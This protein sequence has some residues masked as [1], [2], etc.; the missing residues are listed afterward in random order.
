M[1]R[2]TLII[3]LLILSSASFAQKTISIKGIVKNIDGEVLPKATVIVFYEG[4]KD[5]IKTTASDKGIF[6][7]DNLKPA[8]TG[9]AVSYS[10]YNAFAQFYNYANAEGQQLIADIALTPGAKTL[11]TVVVQAA[12]IQIKEDTVSYKIDSTMYRKNDNV[13]EVLKKL[14]GVEVDKEGKVTAQGEAITKVRVNGKDFFGGDVTSATRNL[15]ADMVDRLDIIDDYGDQA[16]FTGVKDGASTKTLNIQL[17]KDKNKG[18]FGNA[19]LG[20]GT[21]GRYTNSLTLNRFD[22]ER[23]ISLVGSLNNTNESSF[24]FGAGAMGNTMRN[25]MGSSGGGNGVATTKSLGL[26]YRDSWGKK[27]SVNGSYSYTD[28]ATTLLQDINRQNIFDDGVQ[29][30]KQQNNNN[31]GA[32]IHRVN[33]NL[34]YKIDKFNYLKFTPNVTFNTSENDYTSAFLFTDKNNA[35]INEGV[36]TDFTN[37]KAPNFGGNLLFNHRF[38]AK[39]RILSVNL[40]ANASENTGDD[41]YKNLTTYYNILGGGGGAYDSVF[42]QLIDQNNANSS[43]GGD[44]SYIEPLSKK[45]H[46]DFNY[47]YNYQYVD[48]NRQNFVYD[49]VTN[50][51]NLVDSLSNIYNNEYITNRFGVNFITNEKKYKYTIGMAV[52]PATIQSNSK[53]TNIS[54][55]QNLVNFYP[56]VRFT[57]NFSRSRSFS[58]NYQGSTNQPSY[59]QLQPVYDYSNPQYITVGNPDLKPEFT[60][61]ISMRYNNFDL[62]TGN[63]FFGSINFSLVNDK[64]VNNVFNK[65]GG[66]QETR[67]INENGYYTSSAF[68]AFSR[69]FKNRKYVLNYGGNAL[70]NNNISFIEGLKNKGKNMV[71]S[72]RLSTTITLKKWLETNIGANYTYNQTTYSLRKQLNSTLNN[73]SLTHYSRFFLPKD[74]IFIYDINKSINNGYSNNVKANPLLINSSLEKTISKKYNA[75]LRFNAYDLLNEN[76]NVNRVVANNSITDTRTNQLGRYFMMNLI[77]RFSKFAGSA[78]K[79]GGAGA[80]PPPPMGHF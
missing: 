80:P 62:I 23:Q 30:N 45:K 47:S 66:V 39:G 3:G 73:W 33:F 10:G 6:S 44:L 40:K 59:N 9:V 37:S 25:F 13:E 27:I 78:A 72:Q 69:P 53:T 52:Q 20:G 46:L 2:F 24:S 51:P 32:N 16:A 70:Y 22:N 77:F 19:S 76:T 34:E 54:Y 12:K 67:Y 68:Y 5:S 42:N 18:Y 36:T 35:K 60:S 43:F 71:L 65:G 11:E 7:F 28:R 1:I 8:Q 75:S 63:V 64:I 58:L 26:N 14:P 17:K 48:N 57:Y 55:K 15:N 31:T 29:T 61:R 21:E 38:D 74:F 49:N 79:G 4:E 41:L 56:V 50:V